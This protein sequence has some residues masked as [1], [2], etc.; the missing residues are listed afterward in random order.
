MP[1][2]SKTD[3][4][5]DAIEFGQDFLFL[6]LAWIPGHMLPSE[7]FDKELLELWADDHGYILKSE[8]EHNAS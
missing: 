8:V 1:H 4:E 5:T 3:Y 6:I 2:K 7:V